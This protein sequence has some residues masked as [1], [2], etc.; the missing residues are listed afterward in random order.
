LSRRLAEG[1]RAEKRDIARG[2]ICLAYGLSFN[3][4]SRAAKSRF[5]QKE[6]CFFSPNLNV[7]GESENFIKMGAALA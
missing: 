3:K 6:G 1:C 2:L 7:L 4:T 5:R